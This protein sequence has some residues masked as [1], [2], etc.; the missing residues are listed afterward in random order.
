[1]SISRNPLT[2]DDG[3]EFS[4]SCHGIYTKAKNDREVTDATRKNLTNQAP[5][6]M[7]EMA[8]YVG[9]N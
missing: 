8:S 6:T 7:D 5:T 1:M 3:R 4:S 9:L 2:M